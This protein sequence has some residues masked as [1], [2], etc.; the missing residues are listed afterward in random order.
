[1][2]FTRPNAAWAAARRLPGLALLLAALLAGCAQTGAP[3]SSDL[4]DKVTESDEPDGARRAR[5]RLELASA[6]FER[7]SPNTRSAMMLRWISDEP[8]AIVRPRE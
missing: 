5:V 6:Y 7:G 2:M 4:K 8:A 3:T 1:M